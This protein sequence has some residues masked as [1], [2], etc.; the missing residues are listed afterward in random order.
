[1]RSVPPKRR[2]VCELHDFTTHKTALFCVLSVV[3]WQLNTAERPRM[4][5]VNRIN[6]CYYGNLGCDT[7]RMET[8][9]TQEPTASIFTALMT[10][11]YAYLYII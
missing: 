3:T 7:A 8:N 1:M 6:S 9:V 10:K 11:N 5:S 2:T 4:M